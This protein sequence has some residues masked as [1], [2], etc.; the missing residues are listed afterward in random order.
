[1]KEQ[2]NCRDERRLSRTTDRCRCLCTRGYVLMNQSMIEDIFAHLY[3][4]EIYKSVV[5]WHSWHAASWFSRR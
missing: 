2:R 3:E 4:R 1:M 5:I